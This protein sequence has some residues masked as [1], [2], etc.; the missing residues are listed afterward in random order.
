MN[1]FLKDFEKP[2][3]SQTKVEGRKHFLSLAHIR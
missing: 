2:G 3:Q 1:K